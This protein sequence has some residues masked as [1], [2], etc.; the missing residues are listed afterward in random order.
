MLKT[1]L[2]LSSL[3]FVLIIAG[4]SGGVAPTGQIQVSQQD[5]VQSQIFR[6]KESLDLI[7]K[8]PPAQRQAA[9]S[10]PRTAEALYAAS[11]SDPATKKRIDDLGI[12]VS[13]PAAPHHR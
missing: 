10:I 11:Q 3:C 6:A 13:A 5:M 12:K 4:C 8:L 2:I 1:G 7:E 9:A